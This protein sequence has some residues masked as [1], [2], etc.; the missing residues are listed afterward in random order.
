MSNL[1]PKLK[2]QQVISNNII[3]ILPKIS[4]PITTQPE[5]PKKLYKIS[6]EA[7]PQKIFGSTNFL[8]GRKVLKTIYGVNN[9]V[10]IK[11]DNLINAKNLDIAKKHSKLVELTVFSKIKA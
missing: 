6:N 10:I 1:K 2:P 3:S 4:E 9:E 11:K 8:I 7:V 5:P